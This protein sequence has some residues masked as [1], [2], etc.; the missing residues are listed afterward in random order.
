[1]G[2]ILDTTIKCFRA[3]R[4]QLPNEGKFAKLKPSLE[5]IS[6]PPHGALLDHNDASTIQRFVQQLKLLPRGNTSHFLCPKVYVSP[7]LNGPISKQIKQTWLRIDIN[8]RNCTSTG[9]KFER[10]ATYIGQ[11]FEQMGPKKCQMNHDNSFDK[12]IPDASSKKIIQSKRF[13]LLL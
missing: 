7:H 5:K 6:A 9:Q 8:L 11:K 1:M 10:N 12:N 13:C 4:E 3:I 2:H